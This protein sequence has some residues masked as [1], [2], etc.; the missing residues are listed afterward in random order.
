VGL[1]RLIDAAGRVHKAFLKY[2]PVDDGRPEGD[3]FDAALEELMCAEV[4]AR[5]VYEMQQAKRKAV[6]RGEAKEEGGAAGVP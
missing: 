1:K 4:E 2:G 3:E 6:R 5:F